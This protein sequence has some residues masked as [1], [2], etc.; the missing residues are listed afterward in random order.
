MNHRPGVINS[1]NPLV[2]FGQ[3]ERLHF[4]R[5]VILDDQTVDDIRVAYGVSPRGIR[6]PLAF[7]G[8]F[9]GPRDEFLAD[10]VR[11][12]GGGLREIF[13]HCEGFDPSADLLRWMEEHEQRPAAMYVNWIGRTVK[14]IREESK[15]RDSLLDHILSN[16]AAL[17][18][19]APQAIFAELKTFVAAEKEAGRVPLTPPEPTPLGWRVRNALHAAVPF[20]LLLPVVILLVLKPLP[21]LTLVALLAIAIVLLAALF[22]VQLRCHERGDAEMIPRHDPA[23]VHKL[24]DLE[25]YGC[26]N[27][28][29]ALG[30]VKPGIFRRLTVVVALWGLDYATR[31]FFNHGFLTRVRTIHFARWVFLDGKQRLFFASNYDGSLESYMD[32]FI[33]KVGWGLNLVFSNGVCYPR[34]NWLI[35]DGAKREQEFKYFIRRHELATEV[36]YNAHS[37]LTAFDLERNS[38]IRRGIE[39][40]F[41]TDDEI[42]EWLRLI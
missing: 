2:P 21:V 1:K 5:F 16:T 3:L 33:N 18:P 8:D 23:H 12:A 11:R 6:R 27:Q 26:T 38:R 35:L 36:W 31:H 20:L 14:Q 10:L 32:D 40:S 39:K 25:D 42:R 37:G 24:A 7:L 4:A 30:G 13:S 19:K 17:A 9:D 28:F 41:M 22:A 29:S 34:T 15:L